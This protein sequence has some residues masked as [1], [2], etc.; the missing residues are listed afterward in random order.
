MALLYPQLSPVLREIG[1]GTEMESKFRRITLGLKYR[2]IMG[3]LVIWTVDEKMKAG[4]RCRMV[5]A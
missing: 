4:R 3:L 2:K 5:A 1:T